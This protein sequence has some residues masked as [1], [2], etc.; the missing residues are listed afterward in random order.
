MSTAPVLRPVGVVRRFLGIRE[1]G[2]LIPLVFI[3]IAS[4]I[5]NPAFLTLP[6]V[7][8]MLRATSY[9]FIVGVGMTFVLCGRGLDLSVGSQ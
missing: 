1:V 7:L 2:A 3:L 6:N 8:N 9:L 4:A 5:A